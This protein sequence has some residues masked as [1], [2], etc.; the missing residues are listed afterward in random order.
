MSKAADERAKALKMASMKEAL[1]KLTGC[2]AL[3][4]QGAREKSGEGAGTR[5]PA[6]RTATPAKKK[7]APRGTKARSSR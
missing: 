3:E 2:D 6:A 1:G 7:A 5:E 4:A